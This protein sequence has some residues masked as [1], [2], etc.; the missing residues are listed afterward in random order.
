M[1]SSDFIPDKVNL[2]NIEIFNILSDSGSETKT[3]EPILAYNTYKN[4][5][6]RITEI[7]SLGRN[8]VKLV[9]HY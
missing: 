6:S 2:S 5:L 7:R 4:C 9:K 8:K 3:E 1:N